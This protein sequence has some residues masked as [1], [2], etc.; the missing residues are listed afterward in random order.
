MLRKLYLNS[1]FAGISLLALS[2]AFALLSAPLVRATSPADDDVH[3]LDSIRI[4]GAG[5]PCGEQLRTT[6]WLDPT[7]W[8]STWNYQNNY[9][10]AQSDTE[11]FVDELTS[12]METGSGWAVMQRPNAN[13]GNMNMITIQTFAPSAT[14]TLIDGG[15]LLS[16]SAVRSFDIMLNPGSSCRLQN[17]NSGAQS[18]SSY[19]NSIAGEY[20]YLF[21]ASNHIVYPSD[22]EGPQ[23]PATNAHADLDGDGLNAA[24]ETTQGTSN[25]NKDTDGDGLSDFVEST[26]NPN[27]NNVFCGSTCAYPDPT[28][29]DLYVEVDW[30]KDSSNRIF[31]PSPAQLALAVNSYSAKG[32]NAHFDTGQYGGGNELPTYTSDLSRTPTTGVV[33]YYDYKNGG[34]GITANFASNRNLIWHYMIYGNS[35][36]ES[37][38]SSGWAQIM[39]SDIF[40]SGGLVEDMSGLANKDR[41]IASTMFHE[42]GHNLCLSDVQAYAEQPLECIY[43]GVDNNDPNDAQYNLPNYKSVMNYRYQLTDQDDLGVVNYS[44]GTNGTG[45]H[46]DWS[47]VMLGMG[48]FTGTRTALG[49][50]TLGRYVTMPDGSVVVEEEPADKLKEQYEQSQKTKPTENNQQQ[51]SSSSSEVEN[52]NP[53]KTPSHPTTTEQTKGI[54]FTVLAIIGGLVTATIIGL[55]IRYTLRKR[56]K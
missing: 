49:A 16:S 40:I 46:D 7:Q 13:S 44:D 41:A 35:Y 18:V 52:T 25:Y 22:Y 9:N 10:N 42:I 24:Q 6:N 31:K 1:K 53:I 19:G 50:T 27:R 56:H 14:L 20:G 29:K 43:D 34:D 23:I 26:S 36:P 33:D 38:G 47:A 55:L 3:I 37:T 28:Q 5:D 54:D 11:D 51:N 21:V 39:G 17:Y 45:D 30:M 15:R 2:L 32:I 48:K 12:N 4:G 8:R